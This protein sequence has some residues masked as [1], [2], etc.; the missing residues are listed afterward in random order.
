[1]ESGLMDALR[2]D[3]TQAAHDLAAS[4]DPQADIVT[5]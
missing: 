5:A 4:R 2:R 3:E 1:M